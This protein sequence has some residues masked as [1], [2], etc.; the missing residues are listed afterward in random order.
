MREKEKEEGSMLLCD[1]PYMYIFMYIS[2]SLI[3][4]PRSKI[5]E[6]KSF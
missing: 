5:F 6:N 4:T 1:H 3:L 2:I